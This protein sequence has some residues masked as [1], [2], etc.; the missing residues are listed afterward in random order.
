GLR[1]FG[2]RRHSN[3]LELDH[4]KTTNPQVKAL[5]TYPILSSLGVELTVSE[6]A[7]SGLKYNGTFALA[8]LT[9]TPV[10]K[11]EDEEPSTEWK[12]EWRAISSTDFPNL[13]QL[14]LELWL[15]DPKAKL[16]PNEWVTNGGCL[17][18]RFPFEPDYNFLGLRTEILTMRLPLFPTPERAKS[19][20]YLTEP[21]FIKTT[22][23]DAVNMTKELDPRSLEKL[24]YFL[25]VRNPLGVFRLDYS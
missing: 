16:K 5:I 4:N 11:P 15:P 7:P 17:V 25:G 12:H 3:L 9:S 6:V 21:L 18:L 8:Q 13:T 1:R 19:R 23:V 22:L 2:L 10:L 24:A 20:E 14:K